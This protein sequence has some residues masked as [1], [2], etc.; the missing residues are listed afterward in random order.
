MSD[1]FRIAVKYNSADDVIISIKFIT[2]DKAESVCIYEQIIY[3]SLTHSSLAPDGNLKLKK[4]IRTMCS[5][6]E[7]AY[8]SSRP[9][10]GSGCSRNKRRR[11]SK[12]EKSK[13]VLSIV[14]KMK[15]RRRNRNQRDK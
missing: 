10:S 4:S 11:N 14:S 3:H 2:E 13:N 12:N 9:M 15:T 6:L 8:F 5:N 7:V 1:E